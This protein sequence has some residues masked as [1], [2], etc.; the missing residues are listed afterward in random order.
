MNGKNMD[1]SVGMAVPRNLSLD[2]ERAVQLESGQFFGPLNIRYETYGRL[3]S[4]KSNAVLIIH[5]FS[6][7]AHA[8]GRH[9]PEEKTPGWWDSMIGSGKAFDTNLYFIICS[10]I[11]GGCAGTTGPGSI[12]PKTGNPYGLHFPVI[13][14]EDMVKVQKKLVDYLGIKCLLAIAGG[15][16]GGMQV[17]EWSI[18]YPDMLRTAIVIAS[19]SRLSA[20]GIAFDAVGRNA[21]MSDPHWN[22]GNYYGQKN[23]PAKGLAIARMIGHITYLS[24]KSMRIKF[25]RKLQAAADFNF[26]FSDQFQ[27]ES[28]LEYQGDKFVERFDANSYIYLSKAMDY[29]DFSTRFGDMDTALLRSRCS[30]LLISYSSDWLFP[31]YQ[32]RDLVY[33]MIRQGKDVSYTELDSPY[34]H[35]AFLLETGRQEIIIS[36]FLKSAREGKR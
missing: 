26:D 21:I 3:N 18:A 7:D 14:I 36:S 2:D 32:S 28:Y 1:D 19:T 35:D 4:D 10:N 29:Y 13:T 11:F 23:M 15:S 24:D 22:G 25:G 20:Q 8:A 16:M 5:A 27:V 17:L 33:A 12:D 6:G 30:Y 34:G 9:S 31:P